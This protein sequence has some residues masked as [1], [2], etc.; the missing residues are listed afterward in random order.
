[1][2]TDP[3]G[4]F[5]EF[6]VQRD[7]AAGSVLLRLESAGGNDLVFDPGFGD[8]TAGQILVFTAGADVF[9]V[10]KANDQTRLITDSRLR[11]LRTDHAIIGMDIRPGNTREVPYYTPPTGRVEFIPGER[12]SPG[13]S[14]TTREVAALLKRVH[15][16]VP[17]SDGGY[18][19]YHR[20][21]TQGLR[22]DLARVHAMSPGIATEA[23]PP[24]GAGETV[25]TI[26]ELLP[27]GAYA[28]DG[29][30]LPGEEFIELRWPGSHIPRDESLALHVLDRTTGDERVYLLPGPGTRPIPATRNLVWGRDEPRCHPRTPGWLRDDRLRLPNG[31]G[32][33]TLRGHDGRLLDR[34]DLSRHVYDALD[35]DNTR[36]S[37]SFVAEAQ[38]FRAAGGTAAHDH[39]CATRTAATPGEFNAVAP[40][41]TAT[42]SG[43][44]HHALRLYSSR[45]GERVHWKIGASLS[46]PLANGTEALFAGDVLTL[47]V[48]PNAAGRL[49]VSAYPE[50]APEAGLYLTEIFPAGQEVYFRTVAPTPA[51]GGH[52]W[53]RVCARDGFTPAAGS[54]LVITDSRVSDRVV[55][56]ASRFDG[57]VPIP[58]LDPTS[59]TLPPGGCALLIDPDLSPT[60]T[61]DL[62]ER[63]PE[64]IALWTIQT[65]AT[66]G[67]GLASGEGLTLTQVGSEDTRILATYGRPDTPRPF[68]IPTSSGQRV[69]RRADPG[70]MD[71]VLRD[72]IQAWEVAE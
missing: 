64:D 30:S 16:L 63:L 72:E 33:Y 32:I 36:S 15:S 41:F 1:M 20:A 50:S 18:P 42:S 3:G 49:L 7:C 34:L 43:P 66:I 47:L 6:E 37:W 9:A 14:A 59:L 46:A 11:S 51:P 62:P 54:T 5:I 70:N 29:T 17:A 40:F 67:N 48:P 35:G 31:A 61:V 52:E 26:N 55:P 22:P 19:R 12:I 45:G 57:T 53:T 2:R 60:T 68:A 58:G 21:G 65:G 10:Q 25:P 69:E 28:A 13:G 27:A 71:G 4:K 38:T 56:Y 24:R 8:F 23:T 39:A 44:G